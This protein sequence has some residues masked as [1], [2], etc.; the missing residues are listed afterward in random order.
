MVSYFKVITILA[1]RVVALW[2][3][4]TVVDGVDSAHWCGQVQEENTGDIKEQ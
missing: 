3:A 1:A 2:L 4:S